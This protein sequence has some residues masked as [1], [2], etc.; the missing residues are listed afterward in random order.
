MCCGMLWWLWRA[1]VWCAGMAGPTD[2]TVVF[3]CMSSLAASHMAMTIVNLCACVCW[4]LCLL[5]HITLCNQNR[6]TKPETC[7]YLVRA[8]LAFLVVVATAT[9]NLPPLDTCEFSLWGAAAKIFDMPVAQGG[10]EGLKLRVVDCAS[11]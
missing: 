1:V 6:S 7:G 4:C 9:Q 3:G 8:H 11:E 10:A 5:H 2:F